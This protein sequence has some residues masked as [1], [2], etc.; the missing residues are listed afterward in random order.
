M[1][2]SS[3]GQS[4]RTDPRPV[5]DLPG[6]SVVVPV[7]NGAGEIG[8]LLESLLALDYPRERLE[9]IVVDNGSTD[10][11]RDVISGFPVR[12]VEETDT[13]SSYAARNRGTAIAGGEWIAFTDA[14]CVA[15]P[16][17]LLRLLRPPLPAHIGAVAGEVLALEGTTPVQRLM[18]RHG[19][20]K[21]AVTLPH[22][23]LPCFS[24]A[25]VAVRRPVLEKLEGFREDVRYFGDMELAWRM[26]LEASAGIL[27][28]PEAVIR[29]RHRRTWGE[30]WRQACQHGQGVA[31]LKEAYPDHYRIHPG[32]QARRIGGLVA[33]GGRAITGQGARNKS[34]PKGQGAQGARP[35]D[36]KAKHDQDRFRE[37]LFLAIWYAG[38]LTGY[39][40]GP[41]RSRTTS[42]KGG[43]TKKEKSAS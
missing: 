25:N 3:T 14:D 28:R 6:V 7:L 39:V 10:G 24:T 26:Q 22:K 23:N 33:A 13:R 27:F 31:F 21:H 37:P 42:G 15:S 35:A 36:T 20:M 8:R 2:I 19:F 43:G 1:A 11:T 38:L 41:A 34:E 17:W 40:K 4:D 30:L 9:L 29:H 5:D 12:L 18:E 16:D 32:E